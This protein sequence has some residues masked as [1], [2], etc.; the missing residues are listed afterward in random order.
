MPP[1]NGPV[2][3]TLVSPASPSM[4]SWASMQ[5][6]ARPLTETFVVFLDTL[7]P[8]INIRARVGRRR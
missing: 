8:S 1:L 4:K 3:T 7:T 2:A 5:A 6:L